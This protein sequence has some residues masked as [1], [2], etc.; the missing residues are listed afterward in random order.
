M[1]D[2]NLGKLSKWLRILGYDTA[3]YAG[4]ADRN[5]LRAAQ[6]EERVALTRKRDMAKRQFSGQLVVVQHDRVWEQ[7]NEVIDKLSIVPDPDRFFSICLTCNEKLKDV[8]SEDVSGMV[9]DY[10]FRRHKEFHCCPRCG[11]IFWPGTHRDNV[12]S[13]LMTR[14]RRCHP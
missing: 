3:C 9:P 5:F 7:L 12:N 2:S 11:G 1:T 10:T 13:Y 4:K 6:K 8:S 14:I